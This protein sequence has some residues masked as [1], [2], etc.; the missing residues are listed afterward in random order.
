MDI[1]H[2]KSSKWLHYF[3]KKENHDWLLP[4]I[5][6]CIMQEKWQHLVLVKNKSGR[7]CA[8]LTPPLQCLELSSIKAS[9][10]TVLFS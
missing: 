8:N 9:D 6:S 3:F 10:Y 2:F 1:N 5:D 7:M 4:H